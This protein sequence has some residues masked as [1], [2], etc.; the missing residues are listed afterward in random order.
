[1]V[2]QHVTSV[3]GDKLIIFANGSV[4][5]RL[6]E[7]HASAL[8]ARAKLLH[9]LLRDPHATLR[10]T[11]KDCSVSYHINQSGIAS[12]NTS[13][14]HRAV[15]IKIFNQQHIGGVQCECSS[16]SRGSF[17]LDV[18]RSVV[19]RQRAPQPVPQRR[20]R[21]NITGDH[22][23]YTRHA[24]FW[25]AEFQLRPLRGQEVKPL[26]I[27][28]EQFEN[29][30]HCEQDA[31]ARGTAGDPKPEHITTPEHTSQSQSLHCQKA[32]CSQSLPIRKDGAG[33]HPPVNNTKIQYHADT[34]EP[35][36]WFLFPAFQQQVL[37]I[38][39]HR[40]HLNVS[41]TGLMIVR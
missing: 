31:Q 13:K 40:T 2:N 35:I 11:A 27:P 38:F 17:C 8:R 34:F 29:Q 3:W 1:M 25:T 33:T 10:S 36:H 9:T 21:K 16:G 12:L 23:S 28:A 19:L 41:N 18:E 24:F 20:E 6:T 5:L 26:I 15:G 7:T 4:V 39:E 32:V 14:N 22:Q 30:T 37:Q